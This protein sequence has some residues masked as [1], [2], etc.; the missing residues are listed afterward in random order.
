M[1]LKRIFPFDPTWMQF[2]ES[3]PGS[4]VFHHPFWMK[5]RYEESHKEFVTN[6][7]ACNLPIVDVAVGD[8]PSFLFKLEA[9]FIVTAMRNPLQTISPTFFSMVNG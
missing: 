6:M 3:Q 8:V 4:M 5:N 7:N 1:N 2:I 9:A